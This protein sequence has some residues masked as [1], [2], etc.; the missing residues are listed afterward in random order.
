MGKLFHERLRSARILNGFSLQDLASALGDKI[1]RQSLH[2]YEIGDILPDSDMINELSKA[3]NVQ[4]GFFYRNFKVKL[5]KLD[6]RKQVK[7]PAKEQL[8][9]VE[10]AK[11][12]LSRYLEL[13][14]LLGIDAVYRNPLKGLP[15][16]SSF[17]DVEKYALEVRGLW[18]L[19]LAPIYNVVELLEDNHIKVVAV[20][21]EESFD[22]TQTWLNQTIPVIVFNRSYLESTDRIR[23]AILHKLGYLLLPLSGLSEKMKE[24]Y[25]DRFAAAMLIPKTIIQR[26]LGIFRSRMFIQEL[27][28]LKKLYGIPIQTL[29]HRSKDLDILTAKYCKQF[30]IMVTDDDRKIIEPVRYIGLEE[31]NRF[32]RLLF[33][34]LAEKRISVNKAAALSNQ[35]AKDFQKQITVVQ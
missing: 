17:E 27:I 8:R 4:P 24:K 26:K 31:S 35:P 21:S 32:T 34:A 9:I 14:E 5:D 33:R 10:V 7:L 11:E 23:F 22:G 6:F 15:T 2:K 20:D 30:M 29:V 13:E 12:L 19:G 16:I 18:N 3:L 25:C 1:S 28:E